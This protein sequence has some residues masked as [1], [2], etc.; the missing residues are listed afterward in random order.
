[1]AA[2]LASVFLLFAHAGLAGGVALVGRKLGNETDTGTEGCLSFPEVTGEISRSKSIVVRG[3]DLEGNAIEIET[4][5][6]LAR[7][8]LT[9]MKEDS[10]PKNVL[11]KSIDEITD[12]AEIE[13]RI[14]AFEN[15][16]NEIE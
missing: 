3:Q 15:E 6:F 4:T 11:E 5:G 9:Y 10:A 16:M 12:P 7:A 8:I 1:M 2:I 13:E 14:K